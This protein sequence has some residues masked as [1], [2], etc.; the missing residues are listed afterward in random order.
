MKPRPAVATRAGSSLV[1]DRARVLAAIAALPEA[2]R[3]VLTLRLVEELSPLE[4][5]GALRVK[6]SELEKRMAASLRV[7]ARELGVRPVVRRAA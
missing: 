5:A 2:D 6:V 3:L 4:A 1:P 7:L